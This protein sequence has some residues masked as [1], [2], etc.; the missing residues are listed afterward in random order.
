MRCRVVVGGVGMA[1]NIKKI[2]VWKAAAA[3]LE[4][5]AMAGQPQIRMLPNNR[6]PHALLAH[7]LLPPEQTLSI[8]KH[9]AVTLHDY[10]PE[11]PYINV[12]PKPFLITTHNNL[13][14]TF[15]G[16]HKR[17]AIKKSHRPRVQTKVWVYPGFPF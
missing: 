12:L 1:V 8:T 7:T 14:Q 3:V 9:F 13:E 2:D 5:K 15:P 4:R 16:K 11:S 10:R 17:V 6:P